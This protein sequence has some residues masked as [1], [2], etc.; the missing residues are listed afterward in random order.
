VGLLAA[1]RRAL[2]GRLTRRPP[3]FLLSLCGGP[4]GVLVPLTAEQRWIGG[5]RREGGK[6]D[7]GIRALSVLA[8]IITSTTQRSDVSRR[9]SAPRPGTALY[10][11]EQ[12]PSRGTRATG[13]GMGSRICALLHPMR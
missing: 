2:G 6:G 4:G 11:P 9:N 10:T 1:H 5:V 7:A 8:A 12:F 13:T 3:A